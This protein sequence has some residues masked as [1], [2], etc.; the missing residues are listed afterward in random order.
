[1]L[2]FTLLDQADY[3]ETD[4]NVERSNKHE[5]KAYQR[6]MTANTLRNTFQDRYRNSMDT[7]NLAVALKSLG[8]EDADSDQHNGSTQGNTSTDQA[9]KTLGSKASLPRHMRHPSRDEDNEDK[10]DIDAENIETPPATR[11]SNGVRSFRS[12]NSANW[13]APNNMDEDEEFENR[14]SNWKFRS[15]TS[16]GRK[17]M[18]GEAGLGSNK[19]RLGVSDGEAEGPNNIQSSQRLMKFKRLVDLAKDGDSETEQMLDKQK[20]TDINDDLGDGNFQRFSSVRKKMRHRKSDRSDN[21]GSEDRDVADRTELRRTSDNDG[22][23]AADSV[24][25]QETLYSN[26]MDPQ[27]SELVTQKQEDKDSR[28]KRWQKQKGYTKQDG[29]DNREEDSLKDKI[30]RRLFPSSDK[31]NVEKAARSSIREP[32]PPASERLHRRNQDSFARDS[33]TRGSFRPLSS[34][35]LAAPATTRTRRGDRTK[36]AIDPSQVR[37]AMNRN[38]NNNNNNPKTG[39]RDSSGNR[40]NSLARRRADSRSSSARMKASSKDEKDE[41]FEETLSLKSE[42]ASQENSSNGD[43]DLR[44]SVNINS[45][46]HI[47]DK[48]SSHASLRSSRSSLASATS[49]NTVRQARLSKSPSNASVISNRS[50]TSSRS[51]TKLSD[52][53]SPFRNITQSLRRGLGADSAETRSSPTSPQTE[54]PPPPPSSSTLFTSNGTLPSRPI[55]RND[56]VRSVGTFKQNGDSSLRR[57]PVRSASNAS[58]SRFNTTSKRPLVPVQHKSATLNSRNLAQQRYSS[59]GGGSG[60]FSSAKVKRGDSGSSKEN[61]SRS[62]SGNSRTSTARVTP[63]SSVSGSRDKLPLSERLSGPRSAPSRGNYNTMGGSIT[64]R[65]PLSSTSSSTGGGVT[66]RSTL[67][68][69]MRPTTSSSSKK[70]ETSEPV[71]KVRSSTRPLTNAPARTLIK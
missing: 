28:L 60:L 2:I 38:N 23:A 66:Q 27:R 41:G 52:Y 13:M 49:V 58:S 54:T 8:E 62:N 20:K 21:R 33:E 68:A 45:G 35:S 1:M 22:T 3:D 64:R 43:L 53:S 50:D 44:R 12:P 32:K 10:N 29:D 55:S 47:V 42:T 26:I 67:P 34:S 69:F 16:Q 15:M 9:L 48:S 7:S 11:R 30:T 25:V 40:S 65:T 5:K 70:S 18:V 6:T 71:R 46:P 31:Y 56:S 39:V 36:S 61:L 51:R 14:R 19:N 4:N 24:V 59:S 17:A 63:R 57:T 37:E